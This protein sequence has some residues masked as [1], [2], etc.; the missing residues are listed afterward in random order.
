MHP[1]F[2]ELFAIL[3]DEEVKYLVVGGYAVSLHAADLIAAKE[4]AGRPS[5][6]RRR[7]GAPR[8]VERPRCGR[9]AEARSPRRRA[10]LKSPL[11]GRSRGRL[12]SPRQMR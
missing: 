1:D 4:A 7:G 11:S 10:S 6:P 3:N 12:N 9:R 5:G 2:K 8:R